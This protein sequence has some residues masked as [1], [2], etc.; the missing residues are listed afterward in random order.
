VVPNCAKRWSTTKEK[1]SPASVGAKAV[2]ESECGGIDGYRNLRGVRVDPDTGAV[3]HL[4]SN[5]VDQEQGNTI[6]KD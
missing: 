6:V 4:F 2:Q 1:A 5:D 3:G